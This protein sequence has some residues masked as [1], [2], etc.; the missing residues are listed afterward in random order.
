MKAF[1][2][3]GL[4]VVGWLCNH[5]GLLSTQLSLA[6]GSY[7]QGLKMSSGAT[8][9]TS[10]LRTRKRKNRTFP[11]SLKSLPRCSRPHIHSFLMGRN[12]VTRHTSR[13]SQPPLCSSPR[14]GYLRPHPCSAPSPFLSYFPHSLIGSF[15]SLQ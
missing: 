11:L 12:P 13:A 6:F 15:L 1:E 7:F 4:G 9:I 14:P 8:A 3:G 10:T 5:Q 2:I